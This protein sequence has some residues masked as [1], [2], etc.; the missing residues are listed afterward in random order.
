MPETSTGLLCAAR[1]CANND[2]WRRLV[3]LYE[4]LLQGW[5]RRFYEN[6]S[7]VY[8]SIDSNPDLPTST[9]AWT[10]AG[11]PIP[12]QSSPP[13]FVGLID[14]VRLTQGALSPSQFLE[15]APPVP[16]P[17]SLALLVIALSPLG[18]WRLR[19]KG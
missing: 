6:G 19:K 1:D 18:V 10:V 2:A 5:L 17:S 16:E 4:P 7:L 12:G 14:E 8:T 15:A 11:R 3:G 9:G 13:D